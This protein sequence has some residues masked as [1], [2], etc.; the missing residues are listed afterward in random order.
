MSRHAVTLTVNVL[1]LTYSS[2][3]QTCSACTLINKM[4]VYHLTSSCSRLHPPSSAFQGAQ[5]AGLLASLSGRENILLHRGFS[6]AA[7]GTC[8]SPNCYFT[9]ACICYSSGNLG[10]LSLLMGC[11]WEGHPVVPG[12]FVW[13][14]WFPPSFSSG[15]FCRNHLDNAQTLPSCCPCQEPWS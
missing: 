4:M 6:H 11:W 2:L 12:G 15:C 1:A 3:K 7:L 10:S 9:V 8:S 14:I 13:L 5:R